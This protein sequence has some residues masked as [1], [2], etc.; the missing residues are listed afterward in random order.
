M[1]KHW[2]DYLFSSLLS[3]IHV[4][5]SF[6]LPDIHYIYQTMSSMTGCIHTT[7]DLDLQCIF[8]SKAHDIKWIYN[9][10]NIV[11]VNPIVLMYNLLYKDILILWNVFIITGVIIKVISSFSIYYIYQMTWH[12]LVIWYVH[13]M[14]VNNI[15]IDQDETKLLFVNISVYV[16]Y[17]LYT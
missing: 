7:V 11:W 17:M 5:I 2:A 3:H 12:V 10:L 13:I 4:Q 1:W 16:T 15:I 6:N 8:I 14:L 9:A